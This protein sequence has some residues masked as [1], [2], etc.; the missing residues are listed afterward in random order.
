MKL[1]V[2]RLQTE[3]F[4]KVRQLVNFF[5]LRINF[6]F[7]LWIFWFIFGYSGNAKKSVKKNPVF[8]PS[9]FFHAHTRTTALARKKKNIMNVL[10]LCNPS[11]THHRTPESSERRPLELIALADTASKMAICG[12]ATDGGNILRD[13]KEDVKEVPK[14]MPSPMKT[15]NKRLRISLNSH[16][17][18]RVISDQ[19]Q[20]NYHVKRSLLTK[21]FVGVCGPKNYYFFSCHLPNLLPRWRSMV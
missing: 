20:K 17:L 1:T 12:S 18:I 4:F 10:D 13:E 14:I 15:S 19:G 5:F 16:V 6:F 21:T 8:P 9:F 3:F 2:Q 11:F 7:R